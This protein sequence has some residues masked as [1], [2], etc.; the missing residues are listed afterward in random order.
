MYCKNCGKELPDESLFCGYCG[1]ELDENKNETPVGPEPAVPAEIKPE[2]IQIPVDINDFK[3]LLDVLKDPFMEHGIGMYAGIAVLVI[4]LIA[5]WISFGFSYGLLAMMVICASTLAL[6]YIAQR[7]EFSFSK[8]WLQMSELLLVPSVLIALSGVF[9]W[10]GLNAFVV[11]LRL[12]LLAA[13]IMVYV[14]SLERYTRTLNKWG[15]A[16]LMAIVLAVMAACALSSLSW[17]VFSNFQPY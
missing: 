11:L 14:Y 3:P 16:I 15:K 4:T 2:K 8:A 13:A 10:F 9:G 12:F 7:K 5:Y 17:A 6:L 1:A